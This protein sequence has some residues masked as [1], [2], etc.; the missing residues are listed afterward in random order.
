[1][2]A[3]CG[4]GLSAWPSDLRQLLAEQRKERRANVELRAVRLSARAPTR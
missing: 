2:I 1:L 3:E 4:D